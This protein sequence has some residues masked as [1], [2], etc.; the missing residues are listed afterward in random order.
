MVPFKRHR[1]AFEIVER[2]VGEGLDL[3]LLALDDGP[4]RPALQRWIRERSLED[5]IVLLGFRTDFANVMAACD[6][7]VHP[8]LTEASSSVVKEMGLLE[9]PVVACAGVGDFDDYLVDGVNAFVVPRAD[10]SAAIERAIRSAYADREGL[11]ARGRGLRE[12]VLARFQ[13]SDESMA[14]YLELARGVD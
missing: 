6:L 3:T 12:A 1:V 10:P 5:R 2:L 7:L 8:S 11:A 9:R 14:R 13:V 4:D